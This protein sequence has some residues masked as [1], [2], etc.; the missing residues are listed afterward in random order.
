MIASGDIFACISERDGMVTFLEDPEGY[1]SGATAARID[2]AIRRSMALSDKLQAV[3][4]AVS[5]ATGS[6][7]ICAWHAACW[8]GSMLCLLGKGRL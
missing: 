7:W 4:E 6:R 1:N 5:G 2:S 3:H 8:C